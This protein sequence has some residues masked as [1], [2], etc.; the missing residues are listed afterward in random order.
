MNKK[1]SLQFIGAAGTVTGSKILVEANGKKLLVDCGMFQ[2]LKKLRL[3]NWEKLPVAAEEID[4]VLLTH[5]HLDHCGFLPRLVK[6]G[7]R[8]T[9]HGTLPTL[10]IAEIILRDSATLQEEDAERANRH[11]YTRHKPARPLY[12]MRDVQRTV[13]HFKAEP[14]DAWISV[15]EQIRFRFRYNGHIL[16]AAFIELEISGKR[17]V[18]SGDIGNEHDLLLR[19]PARPE[20][21][22]VL[23]I[24]STYG[25]RM[26]PAADP[27]AQLAEIVNRTIARAGSVIIPGFAVE[28]TQSLMFLLWKLQEQGRIPDVPVYMD[29]PMGSRV[30]NLFHVYRDWHKL[31]EDEC[32]QMCKKIRLVKSVQETY[33][34]IDDYHPKI[35][36]AGSGMATGGRVLM[37]LKKYLGDELSTVLLAGYQAPGTRGSDLLDKKPEVKIHG[38][39]YRVKA[40][41]SQIE[42]L[43]AHADQEELAGWM[44]KLEK[45]PGQIFLVHGEET[46]LLGLQKKI[47]EIYGWESRIPALGDRVEIPA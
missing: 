47:K 13:P 29:S 39:M 21:A 8:G 28:R 4:M 44:G 33:S 1:I 15:D 36:I 19:K 30:L 42:G 41:I 18:F 46:G 17:F 40:E 14:P 5:G 12:D 26:H 10:E 27:A 25:D 37:Y 43:S 2:G 34:V 31:H 35:V 16:G 7:F 22:D 45:A 20:Q 32:E 3:L 23:I 9:I 24:E 38:S 11:G 6:E